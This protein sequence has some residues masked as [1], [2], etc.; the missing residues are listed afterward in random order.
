MTTLIEKT[1]TALEAGVIEADG[2]TLFAP[3]HYSPHFTL[4]ELREAGLIQTHESD[5]THKGSIFD[6]NGNV[7]QK[8][9]AVYN[10]E[11]LY[12]LASAI[13]ASHYTRSNGRGSQAQELVDNIKQKLN[14]LGN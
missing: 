12:W 7:I 1:K 13:G 8:L 5:G 9:E 10:L 14:E 4:D 3:E 2:H 11:F 6:A